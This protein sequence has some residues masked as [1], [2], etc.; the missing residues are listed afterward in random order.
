MNN[1][2]SE[3]GRNYNYPDLV[4]P[5][6]SAAD[7]PTVTDLPEKT[8]GE[9]SPY[10]SMGFTADLSSYEQYMNPADR[11]G[12]LLFVNK[13]H[14]LASDYVPVNMI[15][16]VDT[17]K[18]GRATQKMVEYA[19]KALE[20]FLAEA[21]ANGITDVT[22]TSAYRTYDYQNQLYQARI[23]QFSYLGEAAAKEK[24]A[25]IVTPPGTSEHQSGLCADMHNLSSADEAFG[26][27]AAGKWCA[28]NCWRFGF[29]L[30]YPEDKTDITGI[31]YEPWHFRYVGRYHAEKMT[32]LKMCFEEYMDYLG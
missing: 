32:E 17:R 7:I 10:S 4:K 13:Q 2:V 27:T 23:S 16:V 5:T 8:T 14:T 9:A 30:R 28:E 18:D 12:Y 24:A 22:V 25:T 26:A 29:I 19:E 15:N 1:G 11:D 21:R 3:E 20:A 31:I 6:A